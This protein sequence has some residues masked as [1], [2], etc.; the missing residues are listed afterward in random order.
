MREI[1]RVAIKQEQNTNRFVNHRKLFILS[2]VAL[3]A[4]SVDQISK[5]LAWMFLQHKSI[6]LVNDF[7]YLTYRE[8]DAGTFGMLGA[9]SY[10]VRVGLIL[11]MALLIIGSLLL[12]VFKTWGFNKARNLFPL[13]LMMCGALGNG[14]DL[15]VRGYVID[16]IQI[17]SMNRTLVVCNF[18]DI[19][20]TGGWLLFLLFYPIYPNIMYIKKR[21]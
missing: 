20:A 7:L 15:V 6:P 12:L 4:F 5:Q 14:F 16:F 10:G 18:A 8:N 2:F 11:C 9:L 1:E 21:L 19:Y 17:C 3:I 13:V